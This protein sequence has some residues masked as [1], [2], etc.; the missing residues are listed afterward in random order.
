TLPAMKFADITS[1]RRADLPAPGRSVQQRND[2]IDPLLRCMRT[3][4][5]PT[6][7]SVEPL[8]SLRRGHGCFCHRQGFEDLVLYAAC[9]PQRHD[10]HCGRSQVRPPVRHLS[11]QLDAWNGGEPADCGGR[12]ASDERQ[13]RLRIALPN[14]W[15]DLIAEPANP[16]DVRP[17]IEGSQ[18]HTA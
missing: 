7:L 6:G 13:P 8:E 4:Q 9:D 1:A 14:L 12:P 10:T 16:F 5:L 18:E 17:V 2:R 15:P 3:K 11:H